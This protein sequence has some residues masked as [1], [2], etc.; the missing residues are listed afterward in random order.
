MYAKSWISKHLT[1]APKETAP[2]DFTGCPNSLV[3][4]AHEI[5]FQGTFAYFPQ[6]ISQANYLRL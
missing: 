2:A 6:N 1:P 4:L 3:S 5:Y